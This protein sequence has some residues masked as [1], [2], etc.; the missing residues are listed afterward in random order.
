MARPSGVSRSR[1]AASIVASSVAELDLNRV[2]VLSASGEVILAE[3]GGAGGQSTLQSKQ[4]GIEERLAQEVQNMLTARVGAGNARVRV[5]VEL[6]NARLQSFL[7]EHGIEVTRLETFDMLDMFDHAKIQPS[8]VYQE[9]R[10]AVTGKEDAVFV[11]CTQVRAL[12]VVDL[13]ERDLDLPVMSAVQATLWQT[14]KVLGIDP[15]LDRHGSLLR[16]MPELP[17]YAASPVP[18]VRSA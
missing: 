4:S 18:S 2:T 15:G 17:V 9:V 12:E 8:D 5:N 11:A 10:R 16:E 13:L 14:Y 7:G 1:H 3:E 6:T